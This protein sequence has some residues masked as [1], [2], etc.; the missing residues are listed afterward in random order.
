[1]YFDKYANLFIIHIE[2]YCFVVYL[3]NKLL[4]NT[5]RKSC[6][7]KKWKLN[8]KLRK[9]NYKKFSLLTDEW[10]NKTELSIDAALR[11]TLKTFLFTIS[12]LWFLPLPPPLTLLLLMTELTL[13]NKM[14]IL[15]FRII[16]MLPSILPS[17]WLITDEETWINQK[18]HWT[19]LLVVHI[20]EVVGV[21]CLREWE[22][23][24][25]MSVLRYSSVKLKQ[26]LQSRHCQM[27]KIAC[28]YPCLIIHK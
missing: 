1:M 24:V 8:D 9:C 19:G 10:L 11:I 17:K 12:L 28:H 25:I 18:Y 7:K 14:G 5:Q 23:P 4:T 27:M 15:D 3:L 22:Y 2:I 6:R 21:G 26:S 20:V 16:T 13:Q